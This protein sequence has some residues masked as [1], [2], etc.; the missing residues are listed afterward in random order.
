MKKIQTTLTTTAEFSENGKKRYLL[1]KVWDEKKPHLAV[2]MIAP[3]EASGIELDNTTMLVLNNASRLGYGTVSIVN[4]FATIGNLK[5][6]FA[7]ESDKENLKYIDS[8][9][10]NADVI[11][12]ASG[13]GKATNKAFIKRQTQV[14][15]VLKPY[16]EKLRCLSNA[17]GNARFQH[18]LSPAVRTWYLSPMNISELCQE[19]V[20]TTTAKKTVNKAKPNK[21]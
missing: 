19:D 14:L 16:E 3:S 12:Y 7:E 15:E 17:E 4:L 10:K 1:T 20:M 9:A 13:V 2:V 18:P 5:E 6:C 8:T 11:V 21:K